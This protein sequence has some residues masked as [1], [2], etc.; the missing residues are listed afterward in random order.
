MIPLL[1]ALGLPFAAL[2]QYNGPPT[3]ADHSNVTSVTND[4][5]VLFPNT[6]DTVLAPGDQITIR[7]FTD[8]DYNLSVRLGTDGTVLLPLIG[9]VDLRGLTITNAEETI[10]RKLESAGM[11]RNPQVLI[12]ITEGPSAII[13]VAGEMHA[14]IPVVG[15]RSLYAVIAQGGGLPTSASRTVT[16][17]RAGQSQPVTVDIGNDPLHSN[18]GNIPIFPG[19]TVV[20]SRIGVVYVM[21]EFHNPGIVNM[22]NYGPLTLTQ[23]SAQVGGPVYDA[24][25][26]S[27]H[28]IRTVGDHR[29]V[30][31][32]N[33]KD[34]LYGKA[35]D[36]I[37][38]PNDIVFL[39]PSGFKA[40]LANGSLGSILGLISFGIAAITTFR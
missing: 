21:G 29:T 39:P 30:V 36:P 26:G 17:F 6:P 4:Q 1:C 23:V 25:Y 40:S 12:Q 8:T 32:L 15:S 2:G 31:T 16:V 38:Q 37:M 28:I 22:T 7:V 13:T 14:V 27:L 20:V 24:K 33:I 5:S 35:P 34:V 10:A 19:D 11:Y 3:S 9:M 18:A